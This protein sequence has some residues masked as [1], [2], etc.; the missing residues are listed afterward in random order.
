MTMSKTLLQVTPWRNDGIFQNLHTLYNV[1]WANA[2]VDFDYYINHAGFR[3]PSTAIE[4]LC[5]DEDELTHV[6]MAYLAQ[7]FMTIHG[8]SLNRLYAI[9]DLEYNPIQNYDSTERETISGSDGDTVTRGL[10]I[11]GTDTGTDTTTHGHIVDT[12]VD[13]DRSVTGNGASDTTTAD[14]ENKTTETA[15][16]GDNTETATDTRVITTS[17]DSSV[18]N[19][20]TETRFN[21]NTAESVYGFN[22][23]TA[24][25]SA[26]ST[27]SRTSE[28][29][30]NTITDRDAAETH[31]GAITTR[32]L[33][34][35][36]TDTTETT[37]RSGSV[38]VETS[39]SELTTDDTTTTETHSGQDVAGHSQTTSETHSENSTRSG[40][41]SNTRTLT[42]AGNI[43]VTTSQQ[44]IESEIALWQWNFIKN[45][46]YPR[47]DQLLT[48]PMYI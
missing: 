3:S 16:D 11:T 46:V 17:D 42:R 20:K 22:S 13:N 44:M 43:G 37:T 28:T 47:L 19:V 41:H 23:G 15:R 2:F 31:S 38:S 25:P 14:T 7:T 26:E 48:K 24:V 4:Y 1:E 30:D 39:N 21:E 33:I 45:E 12:V 35:E 9:Y 40:T 32:T 10:S 5:G 27:T 29:T 36:D 18:E 6:D 34:D 8:D